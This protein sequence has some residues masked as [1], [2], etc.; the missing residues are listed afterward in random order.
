LPLII[1]ANT[2]SA[3]GYDVDN[4]CR[5]NRGDSPDLQKTWSGT[6]TNQKKYTFSFWVKRCGTGTIDFI[7][8]TAGDFSD[9]KFTATDEFE[10]EEY[11]GGYKYRLK[12][13][14]KFRDPSAWYHFCCRY[15]STDGTAGDRVRLYVNGVEETSFAVDTNVTLNHD[16][17]VNSAILHSI[18][19]QQGEGHANYANHYLSEVVFIDGSSLAPTSFG[20]FDEDSPT[21]WKPIDVSGLTFGTLGFYLDFED[22]GDLGDDE[23]G[24]TND[25]TEANLAAADQAT[26]TPTNN[27]ATVN[28]LDNYYQGHAFSQGNCKVTST[29]SDTSFHTT[30]FAV[31]SGKWYAEVK[32][33][34]TDDSG[35]TLQV[36][37]AG[38]LSTSTTNYIGADAQHF[39]YRGNEGNKETGG[40]N[41]SYGAGYGDNVIVGIYLDLDNNKLYFSKDGTLQN[42]GTGIS[43][44]APASVDMAAYVMAGGERH[45]GA[46]VDLAWN[47][48]GCPSFTVS[49]AV[50]DDNGY[51]SFEYS[52]NI[53]GDSV[54]KSFYALNTKNLAEFGG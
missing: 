7:M 17:I 28:P 26:D 10:W 36:G 16:S 31:S 48:G 47:F 8:D 50:A 21:I 9:F 24:N 49:S 15:D 44:T 12:T 38:K 19:S 53:T 6:P 52:P 5:F 27:F 41:S 4:S 29:S 1:P 18:A 45:T 32:V 43:I 40:S 2:L 54:A 13:N 51:G 30:T 14:R 25:W 35:G 3:A 37:V 42:S 11:T 22:S 23:S 33:D 39:A 46:H 20:E 34:G